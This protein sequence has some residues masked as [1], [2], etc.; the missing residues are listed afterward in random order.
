VTGKIAVVKLI[1]QGH[2][3]VR[4]QKDDR[5]IVIDPGVFTPEADA[6]DG[7]EAILITHEHPDHLDPDRI[8][9]AQADDPNLRIF[10]NRAVAEQFPDLRI[11][12]VGHEDRFT[13]AGFDIQVYGDLHA[14]VHP[15]I[16]VVA[17]S[18][19]LVEGEVFHPGDSFTVP[20]QRVPTLLTPCDAPWLKAAEMLDYL[21]EIAPDRAYS[22][23]DAYVSEIGMGVVDSFLAFERE[24]AGTD[25]RVF[26]AGETVELPA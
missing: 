17:N 9:R 24:R 8:R 10:S 13:V 25:I 2:A 11:Q 19:F 22:I 21:R 6:L 20:G 1:K 4:L 16:P 18:G 7:A 12:R 14:V 3:C 26:K 5:V 23:H 15:D